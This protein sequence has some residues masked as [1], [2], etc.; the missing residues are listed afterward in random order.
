MRIDERYDDLEK[1]TDSACRKILRDGSVQKAKSKA[2]QE[3]VIDVYVN[4][5][6]TM[7]LV[8]TPE[9]LTELVFGRLL[10]EGIITSADDIRTIYI[11]QYGKRARVFLKEKELP[12]K[13]Q[14]GYV[15]MTPTCCT[16]NHILNDYFVS[17]GELEPVKPIP[18]KSEWI[19]ALAEQFAKDTALHKSTMATHSCFLAKGAE[20]LFQC[21]DIGRHNALDKAI[22]Y[23]LRH[24]IDLSECILYSSGRIPTDMAYKVIRAGVPILASKSSVTIQAVELA[25]EY[26]LTLISSAR[27]DYMNLLAGPDPE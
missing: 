5:V 9:Y 13:F 14:P 19:F 4:A 8:C 17:A 25:K 26:G 23:A 1:I 6:L 22:G 20:L 11:C 18:W 16:G 10:T 2:L 27:G 15:E 12:E 24:K 7:K 3:H 21:E